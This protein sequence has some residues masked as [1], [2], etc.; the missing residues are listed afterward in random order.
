MTTYDLLKM[1]VLSNTVSVREQI[2]KKIEELDKEISLLVKCIKVLGASFSK[3]YY[4][5]DEEYIFIADDLFKYFEKEF[6]EEF[7]VK[8]Q[9]WK[10]FGRE[11]HTR[12]QLWCENKSLRDSCALILG[13]LIKIHEEKQLLA[14]T[15]SAV[16]GEANE[17]N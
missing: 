15:L 10:E 6:E 7:D 11:S 1:L 3:I 8:F 14:N 13:K 9:L 5:Q 2:A 12:V 4:C 16:I 17:K